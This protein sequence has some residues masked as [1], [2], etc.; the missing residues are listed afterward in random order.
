MVGNCGTEQEV[1]LHSSCHIVSQRASSL[2]MQRKWPAVNEMLSVVVC[3][4]CAGYFVV[5]ALCGGGPPWLLPALQEPCSECVGDD[6][7]TQF[8][9]LT[10]SHLI[11][12]HGATQ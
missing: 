9:V 6:S 11:E 8:C 2:Y 12:D 10:A 4:P 7:A 5:A 3:A 1:S